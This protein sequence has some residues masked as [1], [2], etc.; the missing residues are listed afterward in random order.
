MP[1]P[2]AYYQDNYNGPIHA[3]TFKGTGFISLPTTAIVASG[4]ISALDQ[5]ILNFNTSGSNVVIDSLTDIVTGQLVTIIKITTANSLTLKNISSSGVGA[6]FYSSTGNDIVFPAGVLGGMSFVAIQ[7]GAT[8]KLFEIKSNVFGDGS[9]LYPGIS[10]GSDVTTG[11]RK[12]SNSIS[13]SLL[14]TEKF[15]IGSDI[16]SKNTI[17]LK[18]GLSTSM[19]I[20][21]ENATTTGF[22]RKSTGELAL[23]VAGTEALSA[24]ADG[25]ILV[26]NKFKKITAPF[27]F[28]NNVDVYTETRMG[29]LGVGATDSAIDLNIPANGIYSQGNVKTIGQFQGTATSA[30]YADLAERYEADKNYTPGTIVMFGGEK[31]ITLAD[32]WRVF[33]IV[34]TNPGFLL[35]DQERT[36][37]FWLPIALIGRVPCRVIGKVK[38]GEALFSIGGGVAS[39]DCE[40]HG[41]DHYIGR[42][43][44]NKETEQEGLVL[45]ATKATI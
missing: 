19:G 40:K 6:K 24:E 27:K 28:T 17:L 25:D 37:G 36:E 5:S 7:D 22:Y 41:H 2:Y 35:N 34:S 18:D 8:L 26:A 20:G 31:E 23:M 14:G 3:T 16:I 12:V 45:I 44:E 9:E 39:A 42:A 13:F 29:S 32:K 11:I 4:D 38:K 1:F 10:F 33:G 30:L 43:L 15:K 21:F